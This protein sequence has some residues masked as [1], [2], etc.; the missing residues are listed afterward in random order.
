[1]HKL[2]VLLVAVVGIGWASHA[3]SIELREFE[4]AEDEQRYRGLLHELRCLVCQN[5]SLADSDAELAQDLRREVHE[6]IGR[7]QS[8]DD[9]VDF[10]VA[11]YGNF[12][13][14][15]PPFNASTAALWVGP[16]ILMFTGLG[17]LW[18]HVRKRHQAAATTQ[19]ATLDEA[20]RK[21]LATLLNPEGDQS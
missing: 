18:L 5:Q 14:Y 12:V 6:M 21:R 13:R 2:I 4:S 10:M 7:G 3:I 17:G 19:T 20:E 16:F 8:D 9:I 1:M 11:R 15:R